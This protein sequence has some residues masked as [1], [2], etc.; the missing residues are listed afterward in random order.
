MGVQRFIN[1]QRKQT[2]AND[3]LQLKIT[4]RHT[5]PPIWRRLLVD[6]ATTFRELH[7]MIQLAMGWE[8]AHLYEFNTGDYKI[9]ELHDDF[10]DGFDD[11]VVDSATVRLEDI[12]SAAKKSFEYIYDFGDYWI[13]KIVVEKILPRDPAATY[14]ACTGGALHCPPEDCG[15]VGGYYELLEAIG[16]EN[17]PEHEEMLEWLGDD[18]DPSY[19]DK[20][21]INT[22]FMAFGNLIT[23]ED[24]E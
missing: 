2:P 13:H 15:G 1:Q 20:G 18:F 3:I 10:F 17:H 21:Y 4:L 19:F 6:K 14:P 12:I 22:L 7:Y 8:N 11:D 23:G 16:D 24:E 5:K 9:G